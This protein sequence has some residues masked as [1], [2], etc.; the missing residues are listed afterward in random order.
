MLNFIRRNGPVCFVMCLASGTVAGTM[1][2][3]GSEGSSPALYPESQYSSA[4]GAILHGD[5]ETGIAHIPARSTG[6][7]GIESESVAKAAALRSAQ[8]EDMSAG[9][10]SRQPQ[11]DL[12]GV[13]SSVVAAYQLPQPSTLH[14]AAT[15][16]RYP[17]VRHQA[18]VS[19]TRG[20]LPARNDGPDVS[21]STRRQLRSQMSRSLESKPGE[22]AVANGS[23]AWQPEFILPQP[24]VVDWNS[25]S[26]ASVPVSE[27][28]VHRPALLQG[29]DTAAM[30]HEGTGSGDAQER[31]ALIKVPAQRPSGEGLQS[32]HPNAAMRLISRPDAPDQI[33]GEDELHQEVVLSTRNVSGDPSGAAEFTVEGQI[34][35]IEFDREVEGHSVVFDEVMVASTAH[36][37]LRLI[38]PVLRGNQSNSMV[39]FVVPVERPRPGTAREAKNV[40]TV[41]AQASSRAVLTDESISSMQEA[42]LTTD[43]NGLDLRKVLLIGT[44][45]TDSD[46]KALVRYPNGEVYQIR[47]GSR[48]NGGDVVAIQ[49]NRVIFVVDNRS[50][51]LR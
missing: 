41:N 22:S 12:S 9:K 5:S 8:H 34:Y 49:Q 43:G 35:G 47:V 44:F 27:Y 13:D 42:I 51:E 18:R 31:L 2:F 39:R 15:Q 26:A 38:Y 21:N 46:R 32:V 19:E 40:P 37:Q 16:S 29:R 50:Y 23:S 20:Y 36:D 28:R 25:Q 3:F 14:G 45:G 6:I 30:P 11:G 7:D 4:A 1:M 24:S 10:V 48:L 17:A 33:N